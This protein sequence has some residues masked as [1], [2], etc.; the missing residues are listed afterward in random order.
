MTL[1]DDDQQFSSAVEKS[2]VQKRERKTR[3]HS[4]FSGQTHT[5]HLAVTV[6]ERVSEVR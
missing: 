1:V 2:L 5:D 6:N 3:E 4:R